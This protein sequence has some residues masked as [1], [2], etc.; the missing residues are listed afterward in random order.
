MGLDRR[1]R[2]VQPRP[3]ANRRREE[4]VDKATPFDGPKPEVWE[5][6]KRTRTRTLDPLIKRQLLQISVR[7]IELSRNLETTID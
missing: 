6:F 4:L 7:K 1:G 3:R 5:A 2:A